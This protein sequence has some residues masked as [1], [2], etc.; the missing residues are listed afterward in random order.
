MKSGA[1]GGQRRRFTLENMPWRQTIIRQIAMP[2]WKSATEILGIT[3]KRMNTP[4]NSGKILLFP[5]I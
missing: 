2:D 4:A 3:K 5:N 1:I